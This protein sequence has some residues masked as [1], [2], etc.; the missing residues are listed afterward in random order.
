MLAMGNRAGRK[1]LY[2]RTTP[3]A[4][5]A[6][7]CALT[8]V[9]GFPDTED[10]T[11]EE[12]VTASWMWMAGLAPDVLSTA[13]LPFVRKIRAI[14][15]RS[16]HSSSDVELEIKRYDALDQPKPPPSPEPSKRKRG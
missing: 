6:L 5:Q 10:M 15:E 12:L 14:V 7:R 2:V 13:L 4:R 8:G 9:Q 16:E 11:Q 1:N 3:E